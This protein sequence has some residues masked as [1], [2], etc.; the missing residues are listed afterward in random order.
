MY[1]AVVHSFDS[2]PEDEVFDIPIAVGSLKL[3]SIPFPLSKVEEVWYAPL[4]SGNGL[5]LS[6]RFR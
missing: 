3:N 1:A 6:R 2:A 4:S 5:Y